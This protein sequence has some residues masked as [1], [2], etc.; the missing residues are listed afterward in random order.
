MGNKPAGTALKNFF[1][2]VGHRIES[3]YNTVVDKVINPVAER[4]GHTFNKIWDVGDKAVGLAG[5]TVDNAE[6]LED[7]A[8]D[9][10]GGIA[11][12][13]AHTTK[14]LGM[15]LPLMVGAG[16][17]MVAYNLTKDRGK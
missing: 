11:D 7:K 8:T 2:D 14:A 6:K 3:G 15:I 12:A 13:L 1:S 10:L 9:A 17:L 4:V 16:V 5:K